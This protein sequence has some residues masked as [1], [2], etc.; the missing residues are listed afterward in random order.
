MN[1]D[2]R[3]IIEDSLNIPGITLKQISSRLGRD[4]KTV[5]EEIKK[6]RYISVPANRRNKCGKQEVCE[7]R[8][9]CSHFVSGLCKFCGHDNCNQLCDEFTPEPACKRLKRFPFVCSGCDRLSSCKQP[10]YFYKAQKAQ[11]ER[12]LS[13]REWKSGPKKSVQ[14]MKQIVEVFER[15]IP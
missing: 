8:R 12:D 11:S 15:G 7:K 1:H 5:R 2:D 3:I 6:H 10:K 14:D 4:G 13:V 9:L